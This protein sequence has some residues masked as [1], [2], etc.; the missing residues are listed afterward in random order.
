MKPILTILESEH[1]SEAAAKRLSEAYQVVYWATNGMLQY[2]SEVL[3]ARTG[4]VDVAR[5][6]KLR[7][8]ASNMT[9]VSHLPLD[10]CNAR[11]IEV[12]SLKGL[13]LRDVHATAEHTIS[14]MLQ[15]LRLGCERGG[16]IGREL[17]GAKVFVIGGGGRIGQ[18]VRYLA[19]S[20]G[21]IVGDCDT[22]Y[23]PTAWRLDDYLP[24]MDIVTIHVPL[25]EETRGMVNAEFLAKLKPGAILVNT[26]RHAIVDSD[27]ILNWLRRDKQAIYAHDFA[28]EWGPSRGEAYSEQIIGTPHIGG[29]T[30]ESLHKT[31][32]LLAEK[33]I[34]WAK[35]RTGVTV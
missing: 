1:F 5:Y 13:D 9:D 14:L 2:E 26:A 30:I 34:E 15:A 4:K 6:P 24:Q 31:E 11:G 29:W 21:A 23:G 18:Q 32:E 17:N 22:A 33:V 3:W 28:D 25:N 12:L 7:L 10:E 35:E 16:K 8:I 27:A 20:F 19:A